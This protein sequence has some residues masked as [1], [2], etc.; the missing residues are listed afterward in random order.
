MTPAGWRL[1][2]H[3]SRVTLTATARFTA[4]RIPPVT[5]TRRFTLGCAALTPKCNDSYHDFCSDPLAPPQ[6]CGGNIP[7]GA[8]DRRRRAGGA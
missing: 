1:M 8:A 3:S 7:R 5:V 4:R 6:S 2:R